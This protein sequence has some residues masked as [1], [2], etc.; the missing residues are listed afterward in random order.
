MKRKTATINPKNRSGKYFQYAE[1]ATLNHT[2]IG[3]NSQRI[4]KFKPLINDYNQERA[5]FPTEKKE[6]EKFE[7][8]TAIA[9]IILFTKNDK[10]FKAILDFKT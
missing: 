5:H 10:R 2:E 3:K 8:I 1:T 4:S 9:V 6:C 7:K